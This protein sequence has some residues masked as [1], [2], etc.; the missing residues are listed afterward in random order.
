[1]DAMQSAQNALRLLVSQSE[2]AW[3]ASWPSDDDSTDVSFEKWRDAV[4]NHW[5]RKVDDAS[6]LVPKAGFKVFDT[7]VSGQVKATLASGKHL[8][9]TRRVRN[10]LPLLGEI[11]LKA[12]LHDMHFDD[13]EF[14]RA[15][16]REIIETGDAPG[17]GL[18]YAQLSKQGGIKKKRNV[19]YVK[20]KRLR[21]DVHEKM[22]GFLPPVP[23]PDPGPV[24]EIV[25]N[26]FGGNGR[27]KKTNS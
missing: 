7:S 19:A 22:V 17:G 14:Y 8:D 2:A 12:G 26:L 18:R 11:Q 23:L 15:L 16:L 9:R 4:L 1:M 24:D 20:S 21:Y 10:P 6:G 25:L 5:G 3:T 13:G 27:A